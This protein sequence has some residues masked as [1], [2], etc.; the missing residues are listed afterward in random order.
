MR[1]F[2]LASPATKIA[3]SENYNTK[4]AV[5]PNR[6][7]GP[8]ANDKFPPTTKQPAI[9]VKFICPLAVLINPHNTKMERHI[10]LSY[11]RPEQKSSGES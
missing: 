2:V 7:L 5:I 11:R 4:N 10:F 6:P 1:P 3:R 9:G 8:N